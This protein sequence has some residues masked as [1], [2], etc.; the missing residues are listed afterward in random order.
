M[1]INE[2]KSKVMI[3]NTAHIYDIEPRLSIHSDEY[4][5]VVEKFK[6]LGV[7]VRSDMKWYENTG[8]VKRDILAYGC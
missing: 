6:L 4:L 1:K 3:F 5:E 8:Y 2:Q 7:I